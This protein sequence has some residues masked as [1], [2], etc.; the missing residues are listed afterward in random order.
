MNVLGELEPFQGNN[1]VRE[2]EKAFLLREFGPFPKK[3]SLV[4]WGVKF[5]TNELFFIPWGTCLGFAIS[6]H[7]PREITS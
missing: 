4:L 5:F 2:K 1:H 7:L 3:N 6:L